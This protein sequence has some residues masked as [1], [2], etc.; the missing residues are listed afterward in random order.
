[1][2]YV[3][4][5][6]LHSFCFVGEYKFLQYPLF[7]GNTRSKLSSG[8]TKL[9]CH[10]CGR[11]FEHRSA[12][13]QHIL[14]HTGETPFH[15]EFCGRGFNKKFNLRVH[16]R[17]HSGERP[18]TCDKCGQTFRLKQALQRHQVNCII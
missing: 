4:I 10:Y 15:C 5:I 12:L 7:T 3:F 18:F 11:P 9:F 16:L 8:K 14:I 6:Y 13:K 1:M 2:N 17:V